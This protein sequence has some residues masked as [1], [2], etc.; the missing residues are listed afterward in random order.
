MDIR[1]GILTISDSSSKGIREDT[2]GNAIEKIVRF[3]SFKIIYRDTLPDDRSLISR[4]LAEWGDSGKL[5]LIL[6]TGGTGLSPRDVTPEATM[7]V[8]DNEVPGIVD[9]IRVRT[10]I[11]TPTSMLSRSVCGTRSGCLI[12]NL[13]GSTTAVKEYLAVAIPVIPHAIE[14]ISG[15]TDH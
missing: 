2:S 3:E 9:V 12:I 13:P 1:V 10:S 7:S 15:S 8:I 11:N 5:D 14:M 6:T 4:K